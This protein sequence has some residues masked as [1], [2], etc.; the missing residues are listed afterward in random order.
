MTTRD[1]WARLGGFDP[2]FVMYGEEADLCRR[3]RAAGLARPRMTPE[4]TII[5]HVGA[6]SG[7]RAE[8]QAMVLKAK[9]TLIRRHLPAW[10]RPLA[11]GLL[12]LWPWTRMIGGRLSGRARANGTAALWAD[13]WRRRADWLPGYP[14]DIS[15]SND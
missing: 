13:V 10:Q 6:S 5:H 11:L 14:E 15:K 7:V 4:A 1:L 2:A 9:A 3:A 12:A 8:R